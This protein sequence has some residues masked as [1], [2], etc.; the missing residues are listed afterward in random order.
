MFQ[1]DLLIMSYAKVENWVVQELE[2]RGA[3]KGR[4]GK[5]REERER[6]GR[7]EWGERK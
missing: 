5:K 2:E 6:E 7:R 4:Q 3:G 1:T